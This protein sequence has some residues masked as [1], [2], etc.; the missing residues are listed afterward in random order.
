MKVLILPVTLAALLPLMF[1][2]E[3]PA[4]ETSL[5]PMP[6]TSIAAL[7][8]A[9]VERPYTYTLRTPEQQAAYNAWKLSLVAV[10]ASQALDAVSSYG[11][12]ELNPVLADGS[13]RFGMKATGVKLSTTAAIVAVQYWI[14]K[15]HPGKARR[16]ALLNLVGAGV[17][18]GFA[19][20]NFSIR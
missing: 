6:P 19:A 14:L 4:A 11:L 7:S 18:S 8:Q 2:A 5:V 3:S 15:S 12:R 10:A 16:M 17:T 1:A 20:H 9:A 13:G